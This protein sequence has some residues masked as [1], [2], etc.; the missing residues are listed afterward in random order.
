MKKT[1]YIYISIKDAYKHEEDLIYLEL[2]KVSCLVPQCAVKKRK[3][4]T[5]NKKWVEEQLSREEQ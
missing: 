3:I 2:R 4:N 1:L 5:S